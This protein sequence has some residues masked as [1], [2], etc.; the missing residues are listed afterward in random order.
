MFPVILTLLTRFLLSIQLKKNGCCKV[1][2]NAELLHHHTNSTV[3][4][5]SFAGRTQ[6]LWGEK[7]RK[8]FTGAYLQHMHSLDFGKVNF[9]TVS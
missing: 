2:V 6:T 1:T 5:K 8:M 7:I 3:Q 9:F 4:N